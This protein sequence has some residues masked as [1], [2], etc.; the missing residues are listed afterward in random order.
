MSAARWVKGTVGYKTRISK[1]FAFNP[2]LVE[3]G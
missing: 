3:I 1:I 2:K